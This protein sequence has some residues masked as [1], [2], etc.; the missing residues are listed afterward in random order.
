VYA[1]NGAITVNPVNQTINQYTSVDSGVSQIVAGSGVTITSTGAS[2]TGV[3]T[4]NATAVGGEPAGSNT[5][6]QFNNAGSFGSLIT[7]NTSK[8]N[9]I[10][11]DQKVGS[12]TN[13]VWYSLTFIAS[14]MA[15]YLLL[16]NGG[17][18]SESN[19]IN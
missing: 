5:Q 19:V 3:V 10:I 17:K 4:I 14:I 6:V 9:P 7:V 13:G 2:G 16:F 8:L 1:T 18:K 12:I 11:P 15:T